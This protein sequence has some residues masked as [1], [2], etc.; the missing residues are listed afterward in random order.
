LIDARDFEELLSRR[1]PAAVLF[2]HLHAAFTAVFEGVRLLAAPSIAYGDQAHRD[3]PRMAAY[4]MDDGCYF[5][6]VR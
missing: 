4:G 6:S 5:T 2:G 1:R 3:A